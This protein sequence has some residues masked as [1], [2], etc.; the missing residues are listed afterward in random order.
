MSKI[1]VFQHVAYE[2]LGTL[3]PLLRSS[4]FRIRYVNFGRHPDIA[5]S[6]DGYH[7]LVVLGGSMNIDQLDQYKHL[8]TEIGLIQEAIQRDL[9]VLGI[10]LGAQLVAKALG[11]EVRRNLEK[12]IGW[13]DVRITGEGRDDPLLGHFQDTEKIF[14]WHGYTFDIPEGA[15]RLATSET[16]INQAFRYGHKVYGFQFHLEVEESLIERW[17]KVPLHKKE[18]EDSQ[19]KIDP[20]K[21]R[22]DTELYVDRLKLLSDRTF[23]RFIKLFRS[24][25]KLESLPS[26]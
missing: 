20:E 26:R 6:L 13:Y 14:Q 25:K 9:P 16:C 5:P 19:G 7:G 15:V 4:G 21:I 1:L 23:G 11:A 12:E 18:I 10:C 17:L 2:I 8:A 24:R 3:D 22:R